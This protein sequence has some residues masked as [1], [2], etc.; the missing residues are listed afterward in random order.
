MSTMTNLGQL[1]NRLEV[2][3]RKREKKAQESQKYQKLHQEDKNKDFVQVYQ[4]GWKRIFYL[5]NK[6]P[7]AAQ[8]Y[9]F[10]AAN[11]DGS[12]VVVVSQDVL[13]EFTGKHVRTIK[14]QTKYLE[15]V[16]ALVRI[17]IGNG[18]YA[19][20]L[21]P[22]EVWKAWNSKKDYAV[23]NTRTLVKRSDEENQLIDRKLHVM[24]K[25]HLGVPE[26]PFEEDA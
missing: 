9:A 2:D 20:A 18:V 26:L 4:Q 15:D 19:Y 5:I 8:I 13:A 22:N 21:N 3:A 11:I 16:H 6:N 14:R 23:F 7:T 25:A 24:L 10:L 1:A 17:R 12:G